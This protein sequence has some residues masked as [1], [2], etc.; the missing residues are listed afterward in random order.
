MT[1]ATIT[2][3]ATLTST[4]PEKV[5]NGLLTLMRDLKHVYLQEV[6]AIRSGDTKKFLSL[7]P[8]KEVLSRD[9]EF[10]VREVQARSAAIKQVD[11]A[12][13][14]KVAVEQA[15]LS[16]LADQAMSLASKM[17]ESMRR[18]H[19]RLIDAARHSVQQE[20]IQYGSA[21][22]LTDSAGA[23]PLATAINESF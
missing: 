3:D 17:A 23:K 9:Y 16:I 19:E 6:D 21:G 2:P 20:K 10:R 11:H 22:V 14:T 5:L 8:D 13:R 18:L 7:Q 15:E 12:L 4:P 1:Q